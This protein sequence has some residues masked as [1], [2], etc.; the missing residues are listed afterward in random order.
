MAATLLISSCLFG[1]FFFF[2]IH[3]CNFVSFIQLAFLSLATSLLVALL[4]GIS[5]FGLHCPATC[6]SSPSFPFPLFSPS[7]L[8]PLVN[9]SPLHSTPALFVSLYLCLPLSV[10]CND[11]M[12]STFTIFFSLCLSL[13]LFS[14]PN[15]DDLGNLSPAKTG[16]T[17]PS[18]PL[19]PSRALCVCLSVC[20]CLCVSVCAKWG[21]LL[22]T[23]HSL[24][25][26][27]N[28]RDKL[29]ETTT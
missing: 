8:F 9:D 25:T 23:L 13:A 16:S 3:L 1:F 18:P 10:C 15:N 11:T 7:L 2:F 26:S 17:Y 28:G 22:W 24:C 20:V 19:S 14:P 27:E 29:M 5:R 21:C 4:F 6:F 12:L